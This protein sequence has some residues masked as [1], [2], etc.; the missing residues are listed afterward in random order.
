[1]KRRANLINLEALTADG[2]HAEQS[3]PR[4]LLADAEVVY[5]VDGRQDREIVVFGREKLQRI[6][7]SEVPEGARVVRVQLSS[8]ANELQSLLELVQQHKGRHEYAES[9]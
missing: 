2:Q 7:E 9:A 5:A 8:G 4:N 1:M 3:D 6:A